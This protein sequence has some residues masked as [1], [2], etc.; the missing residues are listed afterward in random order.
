MMIRKIHGVLGDDLLSRES[1][2]VTNFALSISDWSFML[3]DVPASQ[4][5]P[6]I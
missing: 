5:M 6:S 3:C 4:L 1:I 2:S